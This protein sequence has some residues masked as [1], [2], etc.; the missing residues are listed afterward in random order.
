MNLGVN[1][2]HALDGAGS[3][4]L[5]VA[6]LS[7][8]E[9]AAVGPLPP[10]VD[11][12]NAVLLTVVDDGPGMSPETLERVFEPYF[13]TRP[14]AGGTGLGLSTTFAL[15]ADAGGVLRVHSREGHG[16]TFRIVLAAVE[17]SQSQ[18][19][20]APPPVTPPAQPRPPLR[21]PSP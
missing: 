4:T 7:A 11:P 21:P 20:P 5:T 9:V 3:L 19:E 17:P 10:T 12:A 13:T 1:A 18:G 16:T 15:V 6:P 2:L 14:K 8:D